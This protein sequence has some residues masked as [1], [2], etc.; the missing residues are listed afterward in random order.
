[1]PTYGE[2]IL[3]LFSENE[4][5]VSELYSL[6]ANHFPKHK[7]FWEKIANEETIHAKILQEG[8]EK[9]SCKGELVKESMHANGIIERLTQFI[10]LELERAKN[11][12]ISLEEAV[13]TAL[14]IE[15]SMIEDKCFHIFRP[16]TEEVGSIFRRL[17]DD[18]GN[19]VERLKKEFEYLFRQ[20]P[21]DIS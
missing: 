15:Q 21:F 2:K 4:K 11:E 19:H 20:E 1:M 13:E 14:R 10:D 5:K 3:H 12:I 8:K 7:R 6:Y 9:L 18:T 17:N 16:E